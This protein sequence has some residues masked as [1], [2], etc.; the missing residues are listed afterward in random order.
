MG[1]Y[2]G[3]FWE[4]I[5]SIILILAVAGSLLAYFVGVGE[6]LAAVFGGSQLIW[7]LGFYIVAS[8]CVYC[9]IKLIK[10]ADFILAGFIFLIVLIILFLSHQHINLGNLAAFDWTKLLV[11]YGVVLFACSGL[12]AIPEVRQ[13]L[14]R[15][16]HLFKKVVFL[17][18]L[19]PGIIY[20]IFAWIVVGVT[21]LQTTEV[22]TIGLGQVIGPTILI[23]GNLFA[24]FTM[25]TSFLTLG[26]GL[27]ETLYFDFK[28]KHLWAWLLSALLPLI[29]YFAGLHD[30][31][32]I[33]AIA[34]ALGFGINGIVYIFC[35]WVARK[36][37]KRHPEYILP[38][39]F[40]LPVSILLSVV[41]IGGLIYTII[42]LS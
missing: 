12:I 41:F 3:N 16:E 36:K 4:K 40:A 31:I 29:I 2:L 18:A 11:P 5:T 33:L 39:T 32:S 17:G 9:G 42:N 23:L 10:N 24:F 37:G 20:L 14:F 25:S 22:A 1:K 21:G 15:R 6:V 26:L 7:G 27:K 19:I 30:F 35:Y 34:G 38:K 8:L 28:I 13:I